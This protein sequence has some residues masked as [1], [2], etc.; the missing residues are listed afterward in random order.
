MVTRVET[1]FA[2][3]PDAPER[4][5]DQGSL[6]DRLR[7]DLG[8]ILQ[9][10]LRNRHGRTSVGHVRRARLLETVLRQI[11][12]AVAALKDIWARVEH[13]VQLEEDGALVH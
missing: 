10:C 8:R 12:H 9:P 11:E 2:P 5:P 3:L 4:V 7:Q 6:L 13:G 1:A